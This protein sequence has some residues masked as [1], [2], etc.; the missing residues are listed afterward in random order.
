MCVCVCVCV[1]LF[2]CVCVFVCLCV[3]VCVVCVCVCV[4]CVCLF[5]CVCVC[6]FVC[7]CVCSWLKDKGCDVEVRT[8][9]LHDV[10]YHKIYDSPPTDEHLLNGRRASITCKHTESSEA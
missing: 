4:V 3:C 6:V 7:V 8:T 10:Y 5:V 1:C 2:V 9:G